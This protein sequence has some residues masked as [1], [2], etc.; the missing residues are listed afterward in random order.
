M[1]N[2]NKYLYI[3]TDNTDKELPLYVC[4]TAKELAEKVGTSENSVLSALYHARKRKT[5]KSRY[6][7]VERGADED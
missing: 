1:K 6:A 2:N 3:Y 4:D 5:K 7:R